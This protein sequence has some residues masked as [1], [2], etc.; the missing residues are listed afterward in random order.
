M[1]EQ[2]HRRCSKQLCPRPAVC[3]LTYVYA[4]STAVIGE[5]SARSEPHAYDL[6]SVHADRLTAPKGWS[7]L[8]LE[9]PHGWSRDDIGA[10]VEAVR[11]DAPATRREDPGPALRRSLSGGPLLRDVS[12]QR[13]TEQASRIPATAD[14]S[15]NPETVHT[16]TFA[17]A[18]M[19]QQLRRAHLR[20]P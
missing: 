3:T 19:P 13:S 4:D 5:L 18:P 20:H 16:P 6:C 9:S 15:P 11:D 8:R 14:S 12:F 2:A 7:V 17:P 1:D 10:V